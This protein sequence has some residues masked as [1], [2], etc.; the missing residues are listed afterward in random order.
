MVLVQ[1]KPVAAG[2]CHWRVSK[3][4]DRST[5]VDGICSHTTV[6][7]IPPSRY[8]CQTMSN[9]DRWRLSKYGRYRQPA[10]AR[11]GQWQAFAGLA[12]LAGDGTTSHGGA[13]APFPSVPLYQRKL[14]RLLLP[15]ADRLR[16]RG[17]T[18]ASQ[19]DY[20]YRE[21]DRKCMR[22]APITSQKI[23]PLGHC[24]TCPDMPTLVTATSEEEPQTCI[25]NSQIR[26]M[27]AGG[28]A[29]VP[30][31]RAGWSLKEY[32]SSQL[33]QHLH[34]LRAEGRSRELPKP[35]PFAK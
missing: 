25:I 27:H 9:H 11:S 1:E 23:V 19:P 6:V 18:C 32:R 22:L 35:Q 30:L 7:E 21:L 14:P 8:S 33:K 3:S 20:G 13:H 31:L 4:H 24:S 29:A 15:S 28:L 17:V 2:R 34:L 16:S 26:E 12:G 5:Q 10:N